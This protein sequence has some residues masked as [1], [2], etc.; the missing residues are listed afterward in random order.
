[1]PDFLHL[2]NLLTNNAVDNGDHYIVEAE[3]G[4]VPT[5]CPACHNT[6]Y[7]HGSQRQTYLDTPVHGKRVFIEIDRKRY[8]CKVCGKT[9]FEPLPAMDGK[10]LATIRL[11]QHIERHCLRKTFAELSREVGVDDKTIRHIFDDYVARLKETVVFET[12]EVL[13]IDELKIIGQ[14]RAMITNVEKLALFDMLPTRNK[15]DLIAYFKTMPCKDKVKILTMDL[16]NVYRQVAQ[17]QF[18]GRMVVADRFHVVRMANDSIE[19]VRE[20]IRKGLETK[21]RI[22]LKDDRFV[23]LSREHNLSDNER[24]KLEKWTEM[25]PA[26]G[27]AYKTKE[28]FHD[29][30]CHQSKDDAMKA[31]QEWL[32]SVDKDVAW[33]FR[34]TMGG[35]Q[36][37]W[38]EIFNHYDYPA[39]NACTESINNIA[40]GMNRMGRGYSFDVIRAQLLFDDDA[41][42]DTRTT[43]RKKVRK[44]VPVMDEG[45]ALTSISSMMTT[46][47]QWVDEVQTIEHGPYLPTLAR[48]LEAGEF[49]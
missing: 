45:F 18:P 46:R 8:R 14:Y 17:D 13:G 24:A 49:A 47:Y 19:K 44:A 4:L 12:P 11:V 26:L 1:M 25:F 35:L 38:T 9:L 16:W 34:E 2:P 15:A 5:V 3:G 10:R 6:L 31:A 40:K 23:L 7:R 42:K 41:R 43:L 33:A 22:K 37:W 27:A 39:S 32:Q 21:D 48:K 36:S 20:G 28:A 29:I 30:Y